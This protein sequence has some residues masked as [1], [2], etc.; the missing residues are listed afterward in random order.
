MKTI[1]VTD[2]Q[3]EFLQELTRKMETQSNRATA[4][5]LFYV[6]QKNE[7]WVPAAADYDIVK[8]YDNVSCSTVSEHEDK[9]GNTWVQI[10]DKI[11]TWKCNETGETIDCGEAEDR[12]DFR[13]VYIKLE[14]EPVLG[15]GPFFTEEAAKAHIS[16][17]H[18]H[19]HSPFTYADG[20]WRNYEMQNLMKLLFEV[21]GKKIPMPY[22]GE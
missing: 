6:Y 12:F 4:W 18:Y 11:G 20:A 16:S 9:D 17:N 15:C 22:H 8:F 1:Q 3:Y 2:E 19:Y 13:I 10:D 7:R 5:P 21:L 14:D